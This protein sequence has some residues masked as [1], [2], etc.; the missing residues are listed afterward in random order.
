MKEPLAKINGEIDGKI[1]S[2]K[3]RER[4]GEG[5]GFP[6]TILQKSGE[7]WEP[8]REGTA[9]IQ[10]EG[11]NKRIVISTPLVRLNDDGSP[12]TERKTNK[13]GKFMDRWGKETEQEEN[14]EKVFAL[15]V[16]RNTDKTVFGNK[17]AIFV[18]NKKANGEPSKSTFLSTSLVN[19]QALLDSARVA[20]MAKMEGK[21]FKEVSKEVFEI[22]KKGSKYGNLF[23]SAGKEFLVEQGFEVRSKG[24][25]SPKKKPTN[26]E[27]AF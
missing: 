5:A 21:E 23:V 25:D 6:V 2:I 18:K 14:A 3:I 27:P 26:N 24:D 11:D 8:K 16:D 10:G 19:D 15:V 1:T 12:V 17:M 4:T 13:D 7:E 22:N 20:A 9:F